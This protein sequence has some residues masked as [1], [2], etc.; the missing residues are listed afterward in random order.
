MQ[1]R[2]AT[3][4]RQR[5]RYTENEGAALSLRVGTSSVRILT[6]RSENGANG[7]AREALVRAVA[8]RENQAQMRRGALG[9]GNGDC[10]MKRRLQNTPP[11]VSREGACSQAR[12]P[13]TTLSPSL[14]E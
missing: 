13:H 6:G 7:K 4:G 5:E 8:G 10:V 9:K 14:L 12:D 3:T 11:R 2:R 1:K